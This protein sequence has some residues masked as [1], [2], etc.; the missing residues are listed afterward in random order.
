ML[1]L[2][3]SHD[4]HVVYPVTFRSGTLNS[5]T[6][7]TNSGT[8]NVNPSPAHGSQGAKEFYHFLTL[9]FAIKRDVERTI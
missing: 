9:G 3:C 4:A 6:L 2:G 8:M 1:G 7:N 5:G